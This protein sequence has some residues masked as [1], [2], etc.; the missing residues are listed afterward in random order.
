MAKLSCGGPVAPA[1]RQLAAEVY[2]AIKTEALATLPHVFDRLPDGSLTWIDGCPEY[3]IPFWLLDRIEINRITLTW[4]ELSIL[5][6]IVEGPH[7]QVVLRNWL[8][9]PAA[10]MDLWAIVEELEEAETM[11][12][13]GKLV[14]FS[15]MVP[16]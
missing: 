6:A 8:R 7:L 5:Y 10:G 14:W 1:Q 9:N 15:Q 16:S 13:G 11:M 2:V 3:D 4:W 12:G